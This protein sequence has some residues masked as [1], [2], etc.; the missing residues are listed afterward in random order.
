MPFARV[1]RRAPLSPHIARCAFCVRR[2][3][4]RSSLLPKG[5]RN[6]AVGTKLSGSD[7]S[8][9]VGGVSNASL[10]FRQARPC[11]RTGSSSACW[12]RQASRTA[13][14][15]NRLGRKAYRKRPRQLSMMKQSQHLFGVRRQLP[16]CLY[17]NCRR[18]PLG[19]PGRN[20]LETYVTGH[21]EQYLDI[22]LPATQR[23][24]RLM[25]SAFLDGPGLGNCAFESLLPS[26]LSIV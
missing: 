17:D 7:A 6:S 18:I 8:K 24:T 11:G 1:P 13:A 2:T 4:R 14:L 21:R 5:E 20:R 16:S 25:E 22:V 23:E 26:R 9:E 12:T 3:S 19:R 10:L 15:K